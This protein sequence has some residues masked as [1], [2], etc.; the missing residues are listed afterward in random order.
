MLGICELG[1]IVTTPAMLKTIKTGKD[2]IA[3]L[4]VMQIFI[5]LY[6]LIVLGLSCIV[7]IW[8]KRTAIHIIVSLFLSGMVLTIAVWLISKMQEQIKEHPEKY[9]RF[10]KMISSHSHI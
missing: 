5:L 9:D 4:V 1:Y 6:C 2:R 10:K 7:A 8:V 3:A